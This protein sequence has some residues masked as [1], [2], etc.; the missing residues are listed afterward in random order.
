MKNLLSILIASIEDM[1]HLKE[2]RLSVLYIGRELRRPWSGTSSSIK[3]LHELYVVSFFLIELQVER[4][5]RDD[6]PV[7]GGAWWHVS[8]CDVIWNVFQPVLVPKTTK[9]R[10]NFTFLT[11]MFI[12]MVIPHLGETYPKDKL[13]K[14]AMTSQRNREWVFSFKGSIIL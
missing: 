9:Q 8:S 5:A 2:K 12:S 4:L 11:L 10:E 3:T 6:M 7:R 13:S 14:V 1:R